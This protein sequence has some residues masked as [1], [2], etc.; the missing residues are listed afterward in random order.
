VLPEVRMLGREIVQSVAGGIAADLD[1][2][3]AA[4]VLS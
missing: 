2:R 3:V 4:R 1:L